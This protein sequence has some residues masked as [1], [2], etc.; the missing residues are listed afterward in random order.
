VT[1]ERPLTPLDWTP[2]LRARVEHVLPAMEADAPPIK[3]E[4]TP[5]VTRFAA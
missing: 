3:W 1:P 4:R 5:D 2:E